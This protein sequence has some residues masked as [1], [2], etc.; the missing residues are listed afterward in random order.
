MSR[1]VNNR[2][3]RWLQFILLLLAASAF[4]YAPEPKSFSQFDCANRLTNTIT[5]LG[6]ETRVTYDARGLLSTVRQPS[7]QTTTNFYDAKGRLT[8][9]TDAVGVRWFTYDANN[10]LTSVTNVGQASRLSQTFDAYNRISSYTDADGNL[11]QYRYDA[12]GNLTNLIYPGNRAVT[13]AYDSLNW[14]TNV[15]DWASRRTSIEYDLAS[16]VKKISRPN[17]T[18]REIGCDAA[19]EPTNIVERLA[20]NAPIAFFKLNW[21]DAARV[22]WEFAAPLPHSNAPPARTM[23]FDDDNRLA[24][25]NGNNVTHDSDGNMTYGPG[26]NN[27]LISYGYDAR[28]RLLNVAGVDYGYDPAGNRI[29]VSNATGVTRFVINP[30]GPLSQV[31][32]RVRSGVTNY[33][34]YGVGLCYEITETA[35][36][37][38]TATYHYDLRGSTVALTRDDGLPTDRIEYSAYGSITYRAGNTDTPFLFNAM[39][40]VQTDPNGLLY[41]RARYY[42]PY[43]CRFVNAD[44]IGFAGGLNFYAYANGNPVSLIDPFGLSFWSATGG[45]MKGVGKGAANLWDA[46]NP[47]GHAAQTTDALFDIPLH[48]IRTIQNLAHGVENTF[49]SFGAGFGSGNTEKAGEAAFGIALMLLPELR[50]GKLGEVGRVLEGAEGTVDL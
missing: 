25:F 10:N 30:A 26:T 9:V 33:Y 7:T 49:A 3:R 16:R 20:N 36:S 17:G 5:P 34:I 11:I 8:N 47:N 45:F 35:T 28:G 2:M 44:P 48:P 42:N 50:L 4:G 18:V 13:Y 19:N 14:L 22:E 38:N 24:T 21:N 15:T 23:T 46:I 40:G 1:S 31:L 32:M 29:S 12:N 6:R 27:T 41:M 39:Y 37:T 43:L